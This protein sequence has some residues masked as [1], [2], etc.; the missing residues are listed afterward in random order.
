MPLWMAAQELLQ[1][2]PSEQLLVHKWNLGWRLNN[3]THPFTTVLTRGA[4]CGPTAVHYNLDERFD[5]IGLNTVLDC[6]AGPQRAMM[7]RHITL[8]ILS[9]AGGCFTSRVSSSSRKDLQVGKVNIGTKAHA[10][11]QHDAPSN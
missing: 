7:A 8:S 11:T 3:S 2:S 1:S 6:T 5:S 4:V 9:V 10:H